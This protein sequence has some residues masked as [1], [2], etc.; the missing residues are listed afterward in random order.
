M[1]AEFSSPK[2]DI[3]AR[4][5]GSDIDSVSNP[6]INKALKE[7]NDIQPLYEAF[8]TAKNKLSP[9]PYFSDPNILTTA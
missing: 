8:E 9:H 7:A 5:S 6:K 3:V 1:G 4:T 2:A